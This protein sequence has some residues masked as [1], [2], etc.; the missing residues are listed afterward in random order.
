[1]ASVEE[2]LRPGGHNLLEGMKLLKEMHDQ[3]GLLIFSVF[4]FE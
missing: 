3:T 4:L 2:K 1:M